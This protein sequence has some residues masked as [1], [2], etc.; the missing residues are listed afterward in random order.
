[1]IRSIMSRVIMPVAIIFSAGHC[2]A[3]LIDCNIYLHGNHLEIGMNN[4]GAFGTS[5]PA[6]SG[7]H[8]NVNDTMYNDCTT[9]TASAVAGLGFVADVNRDGWSVGT[10]LY[11][12]DFVMPGH[13]REG[14]AIADNTASATA[15]SYNYTLSS[16]GFSGPLTGGSTSYT[17]TGGTLAGQWDGTFTGASTINVRQTTRIDTGDLFLRVRVGFYNTGTTPDSFYYLRAI[18]PQNESIMSGNDTTINTIEYQLPNPSG[19]V[20]VSATGLTDTNAYI[21]LGTRDP[22]A[23]CFI[24]KDSTLPGFVTLDSIWAGDTVHYKYSGFLTGN[25]GIGLIYKIGLGPGDSSFLDYSY[26]FKGGIIVDTFFDTITIPTLKILDTNNGGHISVYPNPA[27]D[28]VNIRGLKSGDVITLFDITGRPLIQREAVNNVASQ[29][30]FTDN[31]P[32]GNYLLVIKDQY[33][34]VIKRTLVR[35]I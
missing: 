12:G 5:Y 30:I 29:T 25:V 14:W 33:G 8:P 31:L 35:K 24:I 11:F 4:N 20:V 13:P 23:R 7:Y 10:P 26:A 27:N 17:V 16:A 28:L 1:M 22:R 2:T 19:L 32:G 34:N 15:Y 3:Q 6:P 18:D 9:Y 21:A